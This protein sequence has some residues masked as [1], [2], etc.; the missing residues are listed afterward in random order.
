MDSNGWGVDGSAA[1]RSLGIESYHANNLEELFE[2]TRLMVVR[3]AF[4]N[5]KLLNITNF[6]GRVPWGVVGN[7]SNLDAIKA[8]YGM[9]YEYMNYLDF[10]GYMD[11]MERNREMLSYAD[12][13]AG[14]LLENAHSSNM[15]REN[16]AKSIM[17]YLT[18]AS[19]MQKKECNAFTIEC[20]ELCSSLNP[21]NRK[22]TPCLTN[23]LMKDNGIPSAC[24]G[25]ISALLSMMVQM[26]LSNKAIY[27]GNPDVDKVNNQLKIHHSV[28]SLKMLGIDESPS[29][30]EIRSFTVS[31]FGATLRHDFSKHIGEKT[32]VGRFDLT[33]NSMMISSGEITG[34]TNEGCG[35]AQNV[36]MKIPN[37][38]AF[39]KAQQNYG[40]HLT[41]VYGDYTRQIEDLGE[42]MNFEVKNI[43]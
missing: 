18:V 31:G 11:E 24:E 7:I 26:Y 40:S 3:K 36:V 39:W 23:A 8:K 41:F 15:T 27:M 29:P 35:C 10:F 20:F 42:L 19:I 14:K 33:G 21:W 25:D 28:A 16:I 30:Y 22:F 38:R 12:E 5:T 1:I 34:G 43:T 17:F 37:G 32:T 9:D 2:I 4:S 6:P 13:M